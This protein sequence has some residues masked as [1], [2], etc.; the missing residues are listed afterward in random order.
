MTLHR[1]EVT[2]RSGAGELLQ[3]RVNWVDPDRDDNNIPAVARAEV[4]RLLR[5]TL[6]LHHGDTIHVT[7]M[8]AGVT[9]P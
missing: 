6:H 9:A 5:K 4:M 3:R 1:I 7:A 8:D 2:L